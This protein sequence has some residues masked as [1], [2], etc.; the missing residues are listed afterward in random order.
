MI[1]IIHCRIVE[2]INEDSSTDSTSSSALPPTVQSPNKPHGNNLII[3]HVPPIIIPLFIHF[4]YHTLT[5]THTEFLSS[6]ERPGTP[7]HDSSRPET[8]MPL[9]CKF[10]REQRKEF[11]VWH[12]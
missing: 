8:A 9:S 6:K 3:L 4:L 12:A 2:V 10:H 7:Y 5:H 1:A 11:H